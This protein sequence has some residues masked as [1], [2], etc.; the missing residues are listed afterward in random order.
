MGEKN[1]QKGRDH[2][3]ATIVGLFMKSYQRKTR[4][5]SFRPKFFNKFHFFA[6]RG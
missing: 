2:I 4:E 1:R 6:W 3:A 5:V